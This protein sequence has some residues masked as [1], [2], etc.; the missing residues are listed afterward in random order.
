MRDALQK[1]K[2]Y[3]LHHTMAY[4]DWFVTCQPLQ[5]RY[6]TFARMLCIL[7]NRDCSCTVENAA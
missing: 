6:H 7:F 1:K 5:V 3:F 4:A 2:L